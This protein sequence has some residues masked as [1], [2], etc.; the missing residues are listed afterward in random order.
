[1][2]KLGS[3]GEP[4]AAL[5]RRMIEFNSE[6]EKLITKHATELRTMLSETHS[7]S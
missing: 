6:L 1:M 4:E 5:E 3:I 2:V 7:R